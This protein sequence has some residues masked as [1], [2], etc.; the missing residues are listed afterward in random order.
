MAAFKPSNKESFFFFG[1]FTFVNFMNLFL[2][3]TGTGPVADV[4]HEPA[5]VSIGSKWSISNDEQQFN[6]TTMVKANVS[7]VRT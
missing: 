1:I 5:V 4:I 2:E 6:A 3:T 7:H